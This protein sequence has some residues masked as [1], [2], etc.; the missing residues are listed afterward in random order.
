MQICSPHLQGLILQ[1]C[2]M[3]QESAFIQTPQV[4]LMQLVLGP[5]SEKLFFTASLSAERRGK[6]SI[7]GVKYKK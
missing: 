7:K 6:L 5:Q 4:I 2:G 1:L 3:T